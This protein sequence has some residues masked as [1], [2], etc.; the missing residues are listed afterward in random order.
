MKLFSHNLVI[1]LGER[2]GTSE[3]QKQERPS[4]VVAIAFQVSAMRAG[5]AGPNFVRPRTSNQNKLF[6]VF[7]PRTLDLPDLAHSCDEIP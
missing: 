4:K 3:F 2:C 6:D 1:G 5:S 7:F